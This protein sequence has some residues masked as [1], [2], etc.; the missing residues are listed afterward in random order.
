M[1]AL[2]ELR[3]NLKQRI[4]AALSPYGVPPDIRDA[5]DRVAVA[6]YDR[7]PDQAKDKRAE[8]GDLLDL[9]SWAFRNG[10][11]RQSEFLR[12]LY[13]DSWAVPTTP[14][15]PIPPEIKAA[16]NLLASTV[17]AWEED[18]FGEC[19]GRTRAY[20]AATTLKSW[21]LSADLT[22]ELPQEGDD[23]DPY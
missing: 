22:T 20:R 13:E 6:L 3:I 10:S 9:V 4:Q 19:R 5:I 12:R 2:K 11:Q 23:E 14:T 1:L 8:F 18:F 16:I 15:N 21:A 7:D 17:V